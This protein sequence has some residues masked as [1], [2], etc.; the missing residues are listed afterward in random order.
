MTKAERV[1]RKFFSEKGITKKLS[2]VNYNDSWAVN[3][4]DVHDEEV[5]RALERRR[6]NFL[7]RGILTE[8]V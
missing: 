4:I 1:L 6:N 3:G 8:I 5:K 2:V 7:R